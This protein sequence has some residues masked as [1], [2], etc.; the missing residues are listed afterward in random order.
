MGKKGE[1]VIYDIWIRHLTELPFKIKGPQMNSVKLQA[2]RLI[3]RNMLLFYT[4]IINY[5]EDQEHNLFWNHIKDNKTPRNKFN[6]GGE[7]LIL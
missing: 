5:Q 4:L 6:Q 2:T 1:C 7:R 3:Y